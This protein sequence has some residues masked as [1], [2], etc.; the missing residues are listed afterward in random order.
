MGPSSASNILL[1]VLALSALASFVVRVVRAGATE[2]RQ[3]AWVGLGIVSALVVGGAGALVGR[4]RVAVLLRRPPAS[5][6]CRLP[7]S[8]VRR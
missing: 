3:L 1:G 5:P 2:R 7:L 4:Q 8:A 6:P